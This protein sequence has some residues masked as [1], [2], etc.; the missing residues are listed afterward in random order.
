MIYRPKIHV[1]LIKHTYLEF[2]IN[3]RAFKKVKI[4][5]KINLL[6]QKLEFRIFIT[7]QLSVLF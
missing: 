7:L 5:R 1:L 4:H 2:N 6:Q 3:Y